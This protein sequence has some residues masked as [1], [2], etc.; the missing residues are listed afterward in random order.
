LELRKMA[1]TL[2]A[3]DLFAGCG[4]LSHGLAKAGVEVAFANENDRYAAA[5]YKATHPEAVLFEEDANTLL[6]RLLRK[7]PGL[8]RKGDVDLIAGGPPCQGFSGF[9]RF[10]NLQDPRNSLVNTFLNYVDALRP[11]YVLIEN[12]PGML[13]LANGRTPRLLLAALGGM[14]YRGSIG[15]LQAGAYGVPQNRW[16]VVIWAA[17]RNTA[18]PPYPTP[19][20]AF[21]R[22][23]LVGSRAFSQYIVSHPTTPEVSRRHQ[24][25]VTVGD[26]ISDL[27]AI[28]NGAGFPDMAYAAGASGRYQKAMRRG[29]RRVWD[30]QT[31]ELTGIQFDRCVAIPR[32]AGA[33]WL[34]LPPRLRPR[35][36]VRHGDDRYP[37]RF[38]RLSW[39]G[40]FNT[41]LQ[42]ATPYW[43]AVF[44]P[45][46]NRVISVRESARAQSFADATR[47]IGPLSSRYRQIGNA[48]P[49]LL[50]YAVASAL[51]DIQ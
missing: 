39:Q 14:G 37:N 12:V 2:V 3:M 48:V 44:H 22:K 45:E 7:E 9:N 10:R 35:N 43:G 25:M 4:G 38:G 5:T 41:I 26:A 42:R 30:H 36:L 18:I 27:P 11:K 19:T 46:Q 33:G 31:V 34:D 47:F 15:V 21:P 28:E 24:P 32:R 16:R 29:C 1:R 13:T 50:A 6:A 8:P 49:P 17:A 20:H 40:T 23:P 51:M